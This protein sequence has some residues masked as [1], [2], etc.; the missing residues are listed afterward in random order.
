MLHDKRLD[1]YRRHG[2]NLSSR[3]KQNTGVGL[4]SL[5]IPFQNQNYF[6]VLF[7]MKYSFIL[8][9]KLLSVLNH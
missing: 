6:W 4:F 1:I 7:I 2:E 5:E 8:E 9:C 3:I